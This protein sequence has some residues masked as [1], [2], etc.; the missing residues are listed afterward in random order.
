MDILENQQ[1]ATRCPRPEFVGHSLG[2]EQLRAI[3]R[4]RAAFSDCLDAIERDIPAGRERA[5]VVTGLQEACM[6]A[7]RGVSV[8]GEKSKP[9]T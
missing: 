2:D 1:S 6:W 4:I 7:V 3:D 5:L 8:A 9:G